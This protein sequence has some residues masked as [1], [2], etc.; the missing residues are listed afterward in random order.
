MATLK[1]MNELTR[2]FREREISSTKR[3][4]SST[5]TGE[6]PSSR[7]STSS[8]DDQSVETAMEASPTNEEYSTAV[9]DRPNASR[10]TQVYTL[11]LVVVV[12]VLL[13]HSQ[14]WRLPHPHSHACSDPGCMELERVLATLS[15]ASVKACD[16]FYGHVCGGLRRGREFRELQQHSLYAL[17]GKALSSAD[18]DSYPG[19][20]RPLIYF[21]KTCLVAM[22]GPPVDVVEVH[23]LLV[24]YNLS[25]RAF[26]SA[27]REVVI[28]H[29]ARLAARGDY[30]PALR[31]RRVAA[32]VSPSSDANNSSADKCWLEPGSPSRFASLDAAIHSGQV[33]AL[34][35][36]V[37]HVVAHDASRETLPALRFTISPH[38]ME[39]AADLRGN[40]SYHGSLLEG[41]AAA[42]ADAMDVRRLLSDSPLWVAALNASAPFIEESDFNCSP[43]PVLADSTCTTLGACTIKRLHLENTV[44]YTTICRYRVILY[45]ARLHGTCEQVTEP[46]TVSTELYLLESAPLHSLRLYLLLCCTADLLRSELRKFDAGFWA[47]GACIDDLRRSHRVQT[48]N[49]L[50]WLVVEPWDKDLQVREQV[51]A[52]RDQLMLF[53]SHSSAPFELKLNVTDALRKLSLAYGSSRELQGSTA[54]VELQLSKPQLPDP[55]RNETGD[56]QSAYYAVLDELAARKRAALTDFADAALPRLAFNYTESRLYLSLGALDVLAATLGFWA[57]RAIIRAQRDVAP[58]WGL[59]TCLSAQAGAGLS[60][61]EKGALFTAALAFRVTLDAALQLTNNGLA[62][63]RELDRVRLV[64]RAACGSICSASSS[65]RDTGRRP[66]V[67]R[68]DSGSWRLDAGRTVCH[69]AVLN[70]PIFF[71]LFGCEPTSRMAQAGVCPL[72]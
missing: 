28:E 11:Y 5:S 32:A 15:N 51:H 16:D 26:E 65:S 40:R 36:K 7:T 37:R 12:A 64:F 19:D 14:P 59:A 30:V 56:P 29:L 58:G 48:W 2:L 66:L 55:A 39:Q 71:R 60:M 69:A 49:R 44:A 4:F 8:E 42:T 57:A 41:D 27:D 47:G 68:E 52:V 23:S 13:A 25:V 17:L 22:R 34:L 20:V 24:H 46:D 43:W 63:E 54:A 38:E 61:P 72:A 62:T 70:A 33:A 18:P 50:L 45:C 31:I 67:R 9:Q 35:S 53:V 6:G 3:M 21:Y 10:R 1:K